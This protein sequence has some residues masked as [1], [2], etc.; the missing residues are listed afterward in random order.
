MILDMGIMFR[1][2]YWVSI[3]IGP[4]WISGTK[5]MTVL[6][7]QLLSI[8]RIILRYITLLKVNI[9]DVPFFNDVSSL[10]IPTDK[11]S[12]GFLYLGYQARK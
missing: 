12:L 9:Q 1:R 11:S 7:T 10:E 4:E 5:I 8:A 3:K 6:R 2:C